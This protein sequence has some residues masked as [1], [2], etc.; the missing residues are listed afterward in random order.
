M[1]GKKRVLWLL[2]PILALL[3]AGLA[4]GTGYRTSSK[5]VGNS[6]EVRVQMKEANGV[7]STSVELNEDW[8]WD[9]VT[10]TVTLRVSAGSCGATLTGNE[11][12]AINLQAS[13]G[14]PAEMN[15]SL[16]TDGFGEVDLE[17]NCQNAQD[18][19]LTISFSR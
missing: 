1:T 16:V 18:L 7:D 10:A 13:A 11:N 8:S 2:L 3:A 17:T 15:G 14:S 5:I 6:G 4:C 19:D 12:T 9:R